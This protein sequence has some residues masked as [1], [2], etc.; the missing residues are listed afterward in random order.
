MFSILA[1]WLTAIGIQP[2]HFVSGLAGGVVRA[3]VNKHG[4][5]W[6]RVVAGAAGTLCASFLTPFVVLMFGATAAQGAIGFMLGIIGMSLA[7]A[8]IGIGK[9][10]A[11][12]PASLREDL[13]EFLL[14][15]LSRKDSE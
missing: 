15:M 1:A 7:E 5:F 14:K 2:G 4:S 13:R 6:E 3:I 12:N 11:Q 10:Y 8:I 9:N